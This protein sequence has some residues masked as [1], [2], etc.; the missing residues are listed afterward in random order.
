M[1]LCIIVQPKPISVMDNLFNSAQVAMIGLNAFIEMGE[2]K[3]TIDEAEQLR[4]AYEIL[5][6]KRNAMVDQ[7]FNDGMKKLYL[8]NSQN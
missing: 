1:Y 6:Q 5:N 7:M 2:D 4:K 8:V 3:L